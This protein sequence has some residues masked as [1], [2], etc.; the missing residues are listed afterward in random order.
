MRDPVLATKVYVEDGVTYKALVKGGLHYIR[1]N[2]APH[3]SITIDQ[4][5][6]GGADHEL[7]QK[8]WPGKFDDLIA[9]HLSDIDGKPM[10]FIENGWYRARGGQWMGSGWLPDSDY[11]QPQRTMEESVDILMNHLRIT[12][13]EAVKLVFLGRRS[14]QRDREALA[15]QEWDR[16][17]A[18][19]IASYGERPTIIDQGRDYKAEFVAIVS[20]YEERY[21]QEALACIANHNLVVYGDEWKSEG[22][23]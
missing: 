8:L 23:K 19:P 4:Y 14:V 6:C 9:L 22:R 18:V 5:D 3:F 20:T 15:A 21:K 11:G 10:H 12:R 13:D 1:G 7:I 2:S 16:L 17:N